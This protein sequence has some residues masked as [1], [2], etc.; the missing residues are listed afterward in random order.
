MNGEQI[1]FALVFSLLIGV[2]IV[3]FDC[4]MANDPATMASTIITG[5]LEPN[6]LLHR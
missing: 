3:V 5:P 4:R 6:Q 1:Y 2:L